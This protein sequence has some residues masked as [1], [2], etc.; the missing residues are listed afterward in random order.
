MH[1]RRQS[2]VF[3][4]ITL[5]VLGCKRKDPDPSDDGSV[6][7][8]A[9]ADASQCATVAFPSVTTVDAA[10]GASF[11]Q[12]IYAT[13]IPGT[14]DLAVVERLGVIKIVRAGAILPTPF[15]TLEAENLLDGTD[16]DGPST[17]EQGLLGLA[18]H[19]DYATNGRFFIAYTQGSDDGGRRNVIAEWARNPNNH[20]DALDTEV[21]RLVEIVDPQWNHNGGMLLFGPDG[22]LYAAT[23][24]GGNGYDTGSGHGPF[25]NALDK[26]SLLGK[27]LRLDVDASATDF[28]AAG[29]PFEAP[30]GLPQIFAYGLRNPWRMSIDETANVLLLGDVGQDTTE[31]IDALPLASANGANFGWGAY[32]GSL[33]TNTFDDVSALVANRTDPVLDL[34]QS[35][36]VIGNISG[37]VGGYVYRG[38]AI[39]ALDGWYL[40][41]SLGSAVG[42]FRYCGGAA[43]NVQQV[44]S[45]SARASAIASFAQDEDGELYMVDITGHVLRIVAD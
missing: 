9:T 45:L 6:T 28:A 38:S 11:S 43:T 42:A 32:E 13:G 10:G 33:P 30:E 37:V 3:V 14:S 12:P 41:S 23:G 34:P 17:S 29:N 4:A 2:T 44:A 7:D 22:L 27:I 5:A 24:D 8:G 19:P 35:G 1:T 39:P 26:N 18:F 25:G 31:E 40:F 15:L 21:D 20:D 16:L 36:S